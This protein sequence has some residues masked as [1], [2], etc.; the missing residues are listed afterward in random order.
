MQLFCL[1]QKHYSYTL[2]TLFE[3]LLS[4]GR[5]NKE[6]TKSEQ[7]PAIEGVQKEFFNCKER[8]ASAKC[9]SISRYF[10]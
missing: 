2:Y 10:L 3:C 5:A 9:T 8:K 1:N 7:T 4:E 6:R